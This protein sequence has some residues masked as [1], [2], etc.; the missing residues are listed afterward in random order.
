MVRACTVEGCGRKHK[1]R[2][3]CSLHYRH[4]WR[5]QPRVPMHLHTPSL[6]SWGVPIVR[7][8]H[9]QPTARAVA[10]VIDTRPEWTADDLAKALKKAGLE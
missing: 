5:Q 9:H 10:R 6:L 8:Q 3:M 4:W 2:G 1:A 7:T